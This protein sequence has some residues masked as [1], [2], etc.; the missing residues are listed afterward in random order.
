MPS[1]HIVMNARNVTLTLGERDARVEIL[2]GIDLAVEQGGNVALAKAGEVV[3][4]GG[5]KIVGHINMPSRIAVD[6][7]SLYARN[8][9]NFL[10]PLVD[11]ES[12][13]LKINWEDE[14][15][16]ATALTKDGEIIHPNFKA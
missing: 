2:R 10:T 11:K 16:K 7:S 9:V 6:A 3:N 15:V 8:L 1:P 4:G 14:I 5:V 13:N 12:K